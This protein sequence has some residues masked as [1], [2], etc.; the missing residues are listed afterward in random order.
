MILIFSAFNINMLNIAKAD[1]Q[2]K[3]YKN[4]YGLNKH[5]L[6]KLVYDHITAH[7][8]RMRKYKNIPHHEA[9]LTHNVVLD[10]SKEHNDLSIK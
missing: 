5:P 8:L 3:Y 6:R 7:E 10:I 4:N 9:D 2:G 1:K